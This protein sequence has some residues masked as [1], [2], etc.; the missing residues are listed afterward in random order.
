[1]DLKRVCIIGHFGFGHELM[2][3][4][5]VKTKILTA[6]VER[7]LGARQV[8]KIDTHGGVKAL[9]KLPLQTVGA[10]RRCKN[11]VILPANNGLRVLT[12]LL[13]LY[14]RL[15]KRKLHYV[16]IGGWLADF[17]R[18]RKSL[19]RQLKQF[20]GIYVETRTMQKNLEA[21]GFEN[22]HVMPNCKNL[23]P[24]AEVELVYAT[25]EPYRLCTFSRVMREKGIEDAVNAVK[26]VNEQCGRTVYTLDIYGQVDSG[27]TKWFDELKNN[28]PDYV[29]YGG[30]VP[31]DKSVDVLKN[32]FALLF[33][34][35]FYT[36]GIP[37]TVIDAYAAGVPV[38]SAKWESFDDVIDDTH[39]GL[40][41]EFRNNETLCEWLAYI[42]NNPKLVEDLKTNCLQKAEEFMPQNAI[43]ALLRLLEG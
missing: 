12:P 43:G 3:G 15:F 32:Y 7:V 2:N 42:A 22:I 1:M 25:G 9:I 37:G 27:Q 23:Q 11:I 31:Y 33:P 26:V 14:K 24:L 16:V 18:D 40:G 19:T 21:M 20:D 8:Q 10:M 6:E 35:Q 17:I 28:F 34:T 30:L 41:Y 38:I 4:Q 39:T 13:S 5:T 29:K 36:E